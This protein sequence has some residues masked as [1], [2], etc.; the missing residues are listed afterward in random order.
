MGI[1]VRGAYDR[2]RSTEC[3]Y[4]KQMVGRVT[5]Q[6]SATQELC[7][8][9]ETSPL[10]ETEF[11]EKDMTPLVVVPERLKQRCRGLW[12]R[13]GYTAGGE[14]RRRGL[15]TWKKAGEHLLR[16]WRC[17]DD[18]LWRCGCGHGS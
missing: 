3:I 12:P 14:E 18:I 13:V 2:S 4:G 10:V 1:L 8:T 9:K 6:M 7:P 17:G 15:N 16:R 5:A 11:V